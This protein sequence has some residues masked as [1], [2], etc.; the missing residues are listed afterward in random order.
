MG[1]WLALPL[2]LYTSIPVWDVHQRIQSWYWKLDCYRYLYDVDMHYCN[3]IQLTKS[4]KLYQ[5]SSIVHLT[6]GFNGLGKDNCQTR[7]ETFN[8]MDSVPL[9]QKVWWY[10][11]QIWLNLVMW[12]FFIII[13]L[14]VHFLRLWYP[15]GRTEIL[16]FIDY[17]M[18]GNPSVILKKNVCRNLSY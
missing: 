13:L 14:V 17:N 8:F 2:T 7:R 9:I 15:F 11:W 5:A 1:A 6:P 12:Y 3:F 18:F 10:A 4:G 16:M